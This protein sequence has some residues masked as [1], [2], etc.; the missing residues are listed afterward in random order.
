[1]LNRLSD[2]AV[3]FQIR[4]PPSSD[5]RRLPSQGDG[6]ADRTSPALDVHAAASVVLQEAGHEVL[7]RS[8]LAVDHREERDLVA[9]R[10][11]SIPRAMQGD[12]STVAV[13]LWKRGA[14]VEGEAERRRV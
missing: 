1:M 3:T 6:D 11:R 9:G 10:H 12:E 8:G 4:L 2:F 13:L 14:G 7:E 5:T